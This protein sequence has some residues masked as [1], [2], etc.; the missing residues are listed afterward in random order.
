[1]IA[2][3]FFCTSLFGQFTNIKI[4]ERSADDPYVCEPSI[5]INPRNTNNI[6]AG[7]ILD[8]IYTTLD[9]GK[10]WQKFKLTSE[11]GVY[12]DPAIIADRK[13]NFYAFHL[14]DPTHGTG[15]YNSEKL[16]RL[17]IHQSSDGG[18][19][20]KDNGFVGLNTPKDQDK[21][22][23]AVDHKGNLY[24]SWT[25]FDKYGDSS[26][27]CHS[28]IL[29]SRSRNGS[30]WSDPIELSQIPGNC[31]DNDYTAEGAV[32]AVSDEGKIFVAWSNQNQIFMDR[33]YNGGSTWLTNDIPV[34]DQPGG[35]DISV[36]GHDRANG[37]PVLVCNNSLTTAY[38]HLY[39]VWADTRNG[40]D[41]TD[42]WF[43][44]SADNGD[45]WTRPFRIN[46]DETRKHQYLPW[47]TVDQSTGY[48]Y[49][50]YYDRRSYDDK[51]T[52]VYL[53]WSTNGGKSFY[54]TKISETPFIPEEASFFGDYTN[55]TAA[56][57]VIVPV[58][59]RMDDGKTSVW[60]AVIK[61]EDLAKTQ[62]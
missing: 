21:E 19:T 10:T 46:N 17:I 55:I 50:V 54:N 47:M 27:T 56:N 52:D 60:T 20:W 28:R 14:S 45:H 44:S 62:K 59:A 23:P 1:M 49:V 7:S 40:V 12:G 4:D 37:M 38:G 34:V 32:P 53:A 36:P 2:L 25:E 24:L 22:W 57:G 33:S 31:I 29:F 26:S 6:V 13:G 16:D 30:K 35:W 8:N 11:F 18:L 39:I 43:I 61:H 5:A 9:G 48:I 41:D 42:V 51:R 15:G 58:W 3:A